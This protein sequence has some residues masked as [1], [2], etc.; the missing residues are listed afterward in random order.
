MDKLHSI[1]YMHHITIF[2]LASHLLIDIKGDS[3]NILA[4]VKRTAI[5]RY[6]NGSV[7]Y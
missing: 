2:L 3:F 5:N 4:F 1:V 6:T 7:V